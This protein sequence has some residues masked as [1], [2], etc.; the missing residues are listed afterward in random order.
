[1]AGFDLANILSEAMNLQ[2]DQTRQAQQ[3]TDLLNQA[4][5]MSQE[6]AN[7]VGEAG[8]LQSQAEL[9]NLQ[10]QLDTQ[11][12]RVQAANAFGTNVG[13][14]SDIITQLGLQMR[15]QAIELT[16]AQAEAANLEANADLLT[17]P[18]MWLVDLLQG[19]AIRGRR[20]ALASQFDT[21]QKLAQ[22]L[23]AATQA[24]VQ[25][26]NAITE[27]L[28]A[29]SIKDAADAKA[30][31]AEA[32]ALNASIQGKKY[33][34]DAI[35]VMREVG[36]R[37]FNT[38]VQAYQL[39]TDDARWKEGF[40]LRQLQFESL[41][42]DRQARKDQKA[43]Y[44]DATLQI[45][46]YRERIGL[47]PVTEQQVTQ[48]LD[49][50]DTIGQQMRDQQ[51][52][53]WKLLERGEANL[54]GD[55]PAETLSRLQRDQPQLPASYSQASS[56]LSDARTLMEQRISE[57]SLDPTFDKNLLKDPQYRSR[58]YDEAVR[59]LAATQQKDIKHGANNPYQSLPI[60]TVLT[61]A[62]GK[63]GSLNFQEKVLQ[64]LS[65]TGQD[66]PAPDILVAQAAAAIAAGDITISE[67]R[68]GIVDFY[69]TSNALKNSTGGFLQLGLPVAKSY[70]TR[71]EF[72]R[73]GFLNRLLDQR[74][75]NVYM[76]V[77]S[78]LSVRTGSR[79]EDDIRVVGVTGTIDLTDPTQVTTVL[80]INASQR[81][82][83]KLL[84][85]ARTKNQ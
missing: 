45:N 60:S 14:A 78:P 24:T 73:P 51:T 16:Q 57:E 18:G 77:P 63:I 8:R 40:K 52:S 2:G 28:S 43:Y 62:E 30:K 25:T 46:T 44:T 55:T 11:K 26:Q 12:K 23:N 32:D 4:A 56:I 61:E 42:A 64:T 76:N 31:L 6:Q 58:K 5:S 75:G 71:L 84:E 81:R 47:P 3:Q 36:A 53:G 65:S 41:Q 34:A 50:G 49:R 38:S 9:V 72:T 69:Q 80:S 22:G 17:N 21:T 48:R 10:G 35:G 29:A 67:A 82:A 85:E 59:T 13:D 1:M 37:N 20:D 15:E 19:D 74:E 54:F 79:A 66:D 39:Q 68:E 70:N 83:A 33:G 7:L 27:T